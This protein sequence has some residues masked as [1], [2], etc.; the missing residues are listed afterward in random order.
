MLALAGAGPAASAAGDRRPAR[1]ERLHLEPRA[2]RER[3]PE[4]APRHRAAHPPAALVPDDR[5]DP[6]RRRAR[7][8]VV[9]RAERP[10]VPAASA[11]ARRS[12]RGGGRPARF[13]GRLPRDRAALGRGRTRCGPHARALRRRTAVVADPTA[14]PTAYTRRLSL[15]GPGLPAPR[16]C[17]RSGGSCPRTRGRPF[18]HLY[19]GCDEPVTVLPR[20]GRGAPAFGRRL[21]RDFR[22]APGSPC[23]T[24]PPGP[25]PAAARSCRWLAWTRFSGDR[26][27]AMKEEQARLIRRL[28][29]GAV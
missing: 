7:R 22:A 23:P 10:A 9:Q 28:D 13:A 17:A 5:R 6:A 1:G 21:A 20:G 24:R 18:V 14:D 29:P 11:A 12:R 19:T 2:Q 3:A 25:P 4:L 16:R 26:F 8:A 27:F 15:L